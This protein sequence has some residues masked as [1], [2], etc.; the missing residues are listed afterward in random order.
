ME[1]E[2]R[3]FRSGDTV[4]CA[5]DEYAKLTHNKT[6][7]VDAVTDRGNY[8]SIK[9][10]DGQYN[11]YII[12]SFR[13]KKCH[14]DSTTGRLKIGDLVECLAGGFKQ[15]TCGK[16]YKIIDADVSNYQK[17]TITVKTDELKYETFFQHN[18]KLE[19]SP[20]S[21]T[22]PVVKDKCHSD[23]IE[24]WE[25][26]TFNIRS[27]AQ[28]DHDMIKAELSM[29]NPMMIL[30]RSGTPMTRVYLHESIWA[31]ADNSGKI[32]TH[33]KEWW[34]VE[35]V[36]T[37]RLDKY[38]SQNGL[39]NRNVHLRGL[40]KLVKEIKNAQWHKPCRARVTVRKLR[41]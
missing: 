8:I 30:E 32:I 23:S 10:D 4:I 24:T 6:Y 13:L 26:Y 11:K 15:I 3:K 31:K 40:I 14:S 7:L 1:L 25:D 2:S 12:S 33:G 9:G 27:E 22:K 28:I 37:D 39:I 35:T 41:V 16:V 38:M 20:M 19:G 34:W 36:F 29:D 17:P 5:T 18:F 21:I